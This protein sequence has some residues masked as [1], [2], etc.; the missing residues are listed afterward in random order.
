M[1]LHCLGKSMVVLD[2]V[3][4]ATDLL[5]KRGQVYSD[6]PYFIVYKLYVLPTSC[7][8]HFFSLPPSRLGW[9]NS[10]AHLNYG[11]QFQKHRK[12]LQQYLN[13]KACLAFRSMLTEEART[14]VTNLIN[15]AGDHDHLLSRYVISSIY[16]YID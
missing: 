12:L 6:R 9:A 1:Y 7:H 2:S 14:L 8:F 10:V 4:A 3:Q 5:D 11:K 15:N 16:M 13:Q